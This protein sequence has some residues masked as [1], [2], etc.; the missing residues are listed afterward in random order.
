[1]AKLKKL[2][3]TEPGFHTAFD[4]CLENGVKVYVVYNKGKYSVEVNDN[5]TITNSFESKGEFYGKEEVEL[6]VEEI[7]RYYYENFS[8]SK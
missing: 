7:I 2:P 4:W 8:K 1:M 6:K 3:R 5:G